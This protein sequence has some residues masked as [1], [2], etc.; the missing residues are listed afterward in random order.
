MC[1]AVLLGSSGLLCIF[2]VACV[3]AYVTSA[4]RGIYET[5]RIDTPK[6]GHRRDD[7]R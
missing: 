1:N 3:V 2:A 7:T 6:R 5:Q 4:H